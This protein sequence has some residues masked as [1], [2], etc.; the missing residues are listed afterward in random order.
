MNLQFYL[1]FYTQF[2]ESLWVSGNTEELGM[3]DP[4]K[5]I[6]MEYL[7]DE[8]WHAAVTIHKKNLVKDG[9]IYKY[10][11]KNKEDQLIGEWGLDRIAHTTNKETTEIQLI[12]TWNHAGEYENAF[13]SA[14]FKN[15]L[16]KH[17]YPKSKNK[18]VKHHT[19][20]FKIKAPLL[21]KHEVICLTGSGE[22]L[23]NWSED[24]VIL[25]S[26]EGD[27]WTAQIDMTGN[28]FPVAYKYALY[29][30]RE[31]CFVKY[32]TGNNRLLH[33][34]SPVHRVT[35]LHDGFIRMPNDTWK[36]AGVAHACFQPSQQKKFW[37][38]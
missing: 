15:V 1:R 7:N 37:C 17:S 22:T 3:G 26:K 18:G 21:G 36:G 11:L 33:A 4:K 10:Y 32:E 14:A 30:T 27:W 5:A 8:F 19:H 25:L 24:K 34:D 28:F 2:G 38:R 23:G 12:D 35:I 31:N 13:F 29:N 6:A 9:V 16:L 20:I